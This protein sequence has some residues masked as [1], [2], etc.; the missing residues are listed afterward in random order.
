MTLEMDVEMNVLES[1]EA[2]SEDEMNAYVLEDTEEIKR[3]ERGVFTRLSMF[4]P[5]I[6]I[7]YNI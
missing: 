1:A 3:L 5:G 2:P 6:I 4:P 7:S